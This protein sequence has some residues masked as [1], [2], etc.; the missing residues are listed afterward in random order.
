MKISMMSYTMARGLPAGEAFDIAGLCR[1]TRELD[2]E[3]V[4]WVT[5][6]GHE[7]DEVRRIMDDHGLATCCHTF[8]CDLNHPT[9]GERAAGRD[10]FRRGIEAAVAL[11]TDKVMLPIAGKPDLPREESFR[12]VMDGLAEVIDF[13]E[14]AGIVTTVEHFPAACSPFVVSADVNRAVAELPQLR[15]TYDNGNVLT[16]GEHPAEGFT[17][18]AAY[19][20]HAHFKDW[21]ACADTDPGARLC[22]DGKHRRAVLVGDGDVD[23]VAC[24]QAMNAAGYAGYINF[25]YEGSEYTPR[26]ATV[27][28]VRRMREMMAGLV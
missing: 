8:M 11:G 24:L 9:P 13:A 19:I 20:V 25:E 18:S 4:D 21:A 17:N 15:V 3:A 1:F 26:E 6:Y 27:E 12:N 28:G 14:E 16:G 10:V 5:T 23:Q 7:P 22:L 2:L